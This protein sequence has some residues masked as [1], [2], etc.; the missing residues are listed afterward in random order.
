MR[1]KV[2]VS[3]V[4]V[5]MCVAVFCGRGEAQEQVSGFEWAVAPEAFYF[6][7][8]EPG[9]MENEGY[10]WGVA[11]D[12]TYRNATLKNIVAGFETRAALGNVD[13]KSKETGSSSGNDEFL[14]EGRGLVGYDVEPAEKWLL[15]PFVGFAYRYLRDDSSGSQTSTGAYGY[16]RHSNYLYSPLGVDASYDVGDGWRFE[17]RGEFDYFWYGLQ[18]SELGD[19]VSGFPT[20]DNDQDEGYGFRTYL[21][22]AK[23]LAE[24]NVSFFGQIFYN[25]WSIEKSDTATF[26]AN[27]STYEGWE[28]RNRTQELG[29]RLGVAF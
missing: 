19:A 27:G 25:F 14:F 16:G 24:R 17:W 4:A 10:L 20:V 13:Y 12:V 23:S 22:A 1:Q 8:E 18:R 9:V 21:Q 2:F 11:S 7:Y 5:V 6:Y 3:V 26:T 29:F 15:T 28:P